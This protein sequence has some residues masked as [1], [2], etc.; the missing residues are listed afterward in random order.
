MMTTD[1]Y[2]GK[3]LGTLELTIAEGW[4]LDNLFGN[5]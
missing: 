1:V 4:Y 5:L 2:A 3:D